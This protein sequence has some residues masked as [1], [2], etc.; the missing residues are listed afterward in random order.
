MIDKTRLT[1]QAAA[2]SLRESN[3]SAAGA[4]LAA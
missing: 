1:P 2:R 4:M 3:R